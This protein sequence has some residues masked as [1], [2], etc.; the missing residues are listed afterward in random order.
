MNNQESIKSVIEAV[1][2]GKRYPV[3]QLV[4][5][6]PEAAAVISKLSKPRDPSEFDLKN[7]QSYYNL[8]QSQVQAI[9]DNI[10]G[11][12]NDNKNILQLFPD[13]ELAIQILISSILSPKD[14]VSTE[15]IY[16]AKDTLLPAELTLKLNDIIASHFNTYYNIKNEL[17]D[18]L[19]DTLFETGSYVKAVIPEGILDEIINQNTF[20]STEALAEVFTP[21]GDLV[22]IGILG[23]PGGTS[24]RSALE[25]FIGDFKVNDYNPKLQPDDDKLKTVLEDT[26]DI[27]DNYKLLKLPQVIEAHNQ[28]KLKTMIRP[29][30]RVAAEA[31]DKKISGQELAGLIYKGP[32]AKSDEFVVIPGR[33]N[34]K[35]KSVGRPMVLKLPSES[36]IPV[37]I[38]GNETKH[39]GHFV[40]IDIDGNP[41]TIAGNT[42]H[43]SNLNTAFDQNQQQATSLSSLLLTRAKKNLTNS[44]A[45]PTLDQITKVYSNILEKD[46]VERLRN[47]M[48]KT[49]VTLSDNNEVYRVMLARALANQYTRLVYIPGNLVTYFAFKHFDNGVGKSY[50]DNIK[51]LCSLRAILLFSKVMAMTKNSIAVTRVNMTLDPNDPDPQKTIEIAAHDIIKMRQQYFPLGINSPVDLVDWIQRAGFE[52]SFEGHPGLPQTKFDFENKQMQHTLPDNDLDENLRKQTY[53]SVGLSPEVV[54]NGYSSEFATTVI[55]NNIL[56]SKRVIQLQT[57]FSE[58]LSDYGRKLV[59]NDTVIMNELIEALKE[60]KGQVEKYLTDE[61]KVEFQQ[62]PNTFL[63]DILE[64]FVE[65]LIMDLPKPDITSIATQSEAFDQYVESLDKTLDAWVSSEFATSDLVGDISSNIDSIKAVVKNYY[66]RQWMSQ[67][68]FM[69]EL[70]DIVTSDEDGHPTLDLYNISKGHLEGLIKSS[71]RFIESLQGAKDAANA[72][73]S[74]MNVEEG[75]TDSSNDDSSDSSGGDEFGDMGMDDFGDMDGMGGDEETGVEDT[76]TEDATDEA[77]AKKDKGEDTPDKEGDSEN[78]E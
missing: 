35:R 64:R 29:K 49:N 9:S 19:R 33:N 43:L 61:E 71:L 73:L 36:V 30:R 27:T 15:I 69:T 3:L 7:K 48:Y 21:K 60:N 31:Q 32:H 11:R 10:K 4:K 42:E 40:L 57:I 13:I 23:N 26:L 62:N 1:N 68:G 78:K 34:A 20:I 44:D 58:Q 52:F 6:N 28:A 25:A 45:V 41:V 2:S 16:K 59:L 50:L 51:V 39:I 22:N 14:M 63:E 12:V 38:P 24:Q 55:S 67:N 76:G 75:E 8:N 70:N 37:Y 18:C 56:F 66:I 54:D 72:D 65:S 46:L 53:M 17:T 5:S 77:D 74:N 47:G